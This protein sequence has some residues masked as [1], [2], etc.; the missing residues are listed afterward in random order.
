VIDL[1]A[2]AGIDVFRCLQ[3]ASTHES[4][5]RCSSAFP[6]CAC[7]FRRASVSPSACAVHVEHFDAYF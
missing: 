2:F 5:N 7:A 6:A 1:A 4:F 3:H